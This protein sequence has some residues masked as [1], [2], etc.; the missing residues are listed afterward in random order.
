MADESEGMRMDHQILYAETQQKM[1]I[2]RVT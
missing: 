2:I 1:L